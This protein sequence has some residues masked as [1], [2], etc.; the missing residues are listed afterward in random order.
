M[1][2]ESSI[3]K[4]SGHQTFP[5]R[6]GWIYK[7]IQEVANNHSLSSKENIEDQMVSMGMG[8]NMVLSVRHWIRALNLVECT[9][10]KKQTYKLT[11]LAE[12][13]FVGDDALDEYLDK[14]GTIWLLHWLMQS[15]DSKHAELNTARWFFNY[16]N[17]VRVDKLQLSKDIQLSLEN[18]KK[19]I[20]QESAVT[21]AT[22]KKDIDCLFQMYAVKT[23]TAGKVNEDSF[24]SPFTELALISQESAKDYRAELSLQKSLPTAVFGYALINYMMRKQLDKNGIKINN[25]NT[26]AFDSLLNDVGSPGRVFRLSTS[27]LSEKL[28]ELEVLSKGKIAWTDTQGLRQIQHNFED[29]QQVDPAM[30]LEN[31]YHG[32]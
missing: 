13:L 7:I 17:G 27:G 4:F 6:Y 23:T 31:Y 9:D 32:E 12:K 25:N 2:I 15:I 24:T 14:I 30:F 20:G 10:K 3:L 19:A 11:E 29:L 8:K 26:L 22:L 16:F 5:I 18:H 21:D 28:D 1:S